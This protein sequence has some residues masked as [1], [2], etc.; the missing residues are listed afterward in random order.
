MKPGDLVN[1]WHVPRG[2]YGLR[3]CVP[4]RVVRVNPRTIRIEALTRSR[5]WKPL[6]VRPDKLTPRAKREPEDR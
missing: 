4:A 6:S 5:T 1:W 2:G 3:H